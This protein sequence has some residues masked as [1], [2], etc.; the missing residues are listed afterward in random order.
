MAARV[1]IVLLAITSVAAQTGSTVDSTVLSQGN[2]GFVDTQSFYNR[3]PSA[4]ESVVRS[5]VSLS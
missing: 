2:R 5:A 3:L 1:T 4:A